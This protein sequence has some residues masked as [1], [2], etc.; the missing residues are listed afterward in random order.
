MAKNKV[1]AVRGTPPRIFHSWPECEAAVK[2]VA[3]V[4]FKGFVSLEEA[5]IYLGLRKESADELKVYVDGSYFSSIPYAGW[6]WV[7]MQGGKEIACDFG[8][9]PV[10]AKSRNIDGETYASFQAALWLNQQQKHGIICHDYLGVSKWALYEW[11]ANSEIA[12]EYQSQMKPLMKW[13]SFEKVAAHSGIAGNERADFL[14]KEALKP[15]LKAPPIT[16]VSLGYS[17]LS[18]PEKAEIV[19]EVV[20]EWPKIEVPQVEESSK[21]SKPTKA[22]ISEQIALF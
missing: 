11:K 20:R 3:G 13:V 10:E 1:Y 15:S 21:S 6:A 18:I 8:K 22:Q 4:Q 14:A 5:E 19:A 12:Q 7:A 9:T 16:Q 17:P 2:G